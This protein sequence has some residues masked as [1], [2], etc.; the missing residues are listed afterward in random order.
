MTTAPKKDQKD[1]H[2]DVQTN[3]KRGILQK[4][5]KQAGL[6]GAGSAIRDDSLGKKPLSGCVVQRKQ[7]NISGPENG[8][9]VEKARCESIEKKK[10]GTRKQCHLD[11][12]WF[13]G[14]TKLNSKK[15]RSA[16]RKANRKVGNSVP[17]AKR[18]TIGKGRMKKSGWGRCHPCP[19]MSM[20]KRGE[21]GVGI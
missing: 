10:V 14:V 6:K 2:V 18:I 19:V 15:R 3:Q 4:R 20:E 8:W 17:R 11:M 16:I 1:H 9:R 13:T 5:R 21:N 7:N 12:N